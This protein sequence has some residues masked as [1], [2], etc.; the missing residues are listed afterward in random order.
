VNRPPP[1]RSSARV[2]VGSA[3]VVALLVAGSIGLTGSARAGYPPLPIAYD[4][5]FIQNLSAP[6]L[7]PGD[8]GTIDLTL[9]NPF[10]IS[11]SIESLNLT[12]YAFNAY[13][14]N[15]TGP[16][17]SGGSPTFANGLTSTTVT[18]TVL[19]PHELDPIGVAIAAP[20]SAAIGDYAFRL[21]ELCSAN[22]TGYRLNSR[23]FYSD[24]QWANATTLPNGSATLNLTRLGVSGIVPES[25]VLVQSN[26]YAFPLDLILGLA[27]ALAAAGGYY[28]WRRGPGSN[29]GARTVPVDKSAPKAL[30]TS[31][32]KD[33]D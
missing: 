29:S 10:A 4:S 17:P 11:L 26:P 13:P 5:K 32:T 27:L 28:A 33:G 18:P 30:G 8:G 21:S 2:V 19:G 23:G 14:G 24:S 22:G 3:L 20:T 7:A 9:G 31:R 15:A 1:S 16:L 6:V 25:A 12:F